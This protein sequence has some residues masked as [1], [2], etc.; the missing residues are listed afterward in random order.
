MPAT[1]PL[2]TQRIRIESSKNA[3]LA[4]ISCWTLPLFRWSRKLAFPTCQSFVTAAKSPRRDKLG[5]LAEDAVVLHR[6]YSGCAS[7]RHSFVV[8]DLI[9]Q[10]KIRNLQ[11]QHVVHNRR[12]KLRGP[13]N[14]HQIDAGSSLLARSSLRCLQVGIARHS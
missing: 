4:A 9:L 8:L 12:Y 11:A 14:I 6:F 3:F 13:E 2:P 5:M 1:P 10:P 7:P